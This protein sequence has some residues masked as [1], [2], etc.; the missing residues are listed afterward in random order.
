MRRCAG[1]DEVFQLGLGKSG[2]TT[3]KKYFSDTYDYNVTCGDKLTAL[4]QAEA[5]ARRPLLDAARAL[6]PHFYI[7][8]LLRV[9]WPAESIALQLTDLHA[10]RVGAPKALF[11]HCARNVT[12]WASSVANWY[13]LQARLAQRDLPGL[14]RGIGQR[15]EELEQWYEGVNAHIAFQFA[16]RD[17]YVRVNVDSF[18]SLRALEQFCDRHSQAYH[19]V[20][21][22]VNRH[23]A[24][25]RGT[26]RCKECTLRYRRAI[27]RT[28]AVTW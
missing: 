3:V 21:Q 20:P 14:P 2:T 22:N 10:L 19:W 25:R 18:A 7:S 5:N 26:T 9:Y 24:M 27:K 12:K 16:Y 11:V 1:Y 6:C 13:S 28:K 23:A 8:E 17:N 4:I 15:R